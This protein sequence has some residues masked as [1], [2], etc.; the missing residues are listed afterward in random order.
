MSN[1]IMTAAGSRQVEK[2]L[3]V[4]MDVIPKPSSKGR[5][6]TEISLIRAFWGVS[7]NF[8]CNPLL[9]Q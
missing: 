5:F 3:V 8:I 1:V 7:L 2:N 6:F 4:A 9:D